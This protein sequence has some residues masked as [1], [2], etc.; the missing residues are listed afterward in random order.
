[1]SWKYRQSTGEFWLDGKLLGVGYSGHGEGKNN[2]ELE[3]V[4]AVG[5]I[6]RGRWRVAGWKDSPNTGPLSILLEPVGHD[7]HGRTLFRI[8]G[9]SVSAPGTASHGCIILT[10]SARRRIVASKDL[11]GWVV[12]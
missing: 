3:A 2:P 4:R 9:D 10:R 12:A 8:H 7:A 1:M 6:P 5:P 11:E